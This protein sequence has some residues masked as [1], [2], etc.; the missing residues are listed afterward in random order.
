MRHAMTHSRPRAHTLRGFSLIELMVSI[1]IGLFILIAVGVVFL[2]STQSARQRE[3][4]AEL[5]DPARMALN[6]L[7][8]LISQAGYVDLFDSDRSSAG[9]APVQAAQLFQ[10]SSD[11]L[12]NLYAR[13]PGAAPADSPVGILFPGLMPV[14]GCAGA[15]TTTPIAL[16]KATSASV[17]VGCGAANALQQTIQLVQQAVPITAAPV[18]GASNFTS[19]QAADS[20]T[21]AGFDCLQQGVPTGVTLTRGKTFVI[22]RFFIKSTDG[23]NE[24]H[25][26]GSGNA[27]SQ[28]IARGVEELTFRY[29]LGRSLPAAGVAGGTSARY[30]GADEVAVDAVGWAA[31]T[32]VEVCMVSATADVNGVAAMGTTALQAT[33]P[34]CARDATGQFS[35]NVARA[36]GDNRLWKR[37]TSVIAVRN[38][39]FLSPS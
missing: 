20:T 16:V 25:C 17:S 13:V 26:Q 23:V 34:T 21:G 3:N 37:F 19:L 35:A 5:N 39:L 22:N 33:R 38:A 28:P 2:N 36:G 8:G 29:Q 31:V 32:A 4:Q 14:F 27:A 30:V 18:T 15:M 11:K 10:P 1:T 7:R 9:V 6:Q 12:I 24:L